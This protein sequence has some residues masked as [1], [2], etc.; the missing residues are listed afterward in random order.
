MRRLSI[1]VKHQPKPLYYAPD[2]GY[3]TRGYSPGFAEENAA[4][5]EAGYPRHI[6]HVWCNN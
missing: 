2:C 6:V 3:E 4:W 1:D 5:H